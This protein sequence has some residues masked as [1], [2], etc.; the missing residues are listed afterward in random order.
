LPSQRC[1]QAK[2]YAK[3]PG[4]ADDDDADDRRFD[5]NPDE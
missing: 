2:P 1:P 4:V 3:D 5:G